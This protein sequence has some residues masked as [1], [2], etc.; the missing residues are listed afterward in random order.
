MEMSGFPPR[1]THSGS[2]RSFER[3]N[4]KMSPSREPQPVPCRTAE[5]GRGQ[6][7]CAMYG[8]VWFSSTWDSL[9]IDEKL[10]EKQ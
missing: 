10:R 2:T 3:S 7:E 6:E 5:E 9:R 1:G 8:D 4:R